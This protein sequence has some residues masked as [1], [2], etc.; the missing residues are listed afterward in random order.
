MDLKYSLG[1]DLGRVLVHAT[2]VIMPWLSIVWL[3]EV[4]V[5]ECGNK[6]SLPV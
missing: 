2:T 1:H 3:F 4:L 5:S 6:A